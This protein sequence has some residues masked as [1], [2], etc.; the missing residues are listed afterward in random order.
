[1]KTRPVCAALILVS[2]LSGCARVPVNQLT[3]YQR[4]VAVTSME[5][6]A[7]ILAKAELRETKDP[8]LNH[9]KA[10]YLSGSP[11]EMGFQHGR[12][13]AA[14]VRS[15]VSHVIRRVLMV[16]EADMLDEVYDLMAFHI[17]VEE[18]EEMRGLAHGAGL[19]LRVIHWLHVIPEVSEFGGRKK[20]RK[21]RNGTSCSNVAAF[22][23]ATRDGSLLQL[24][25]LDW[26]RELGVHQ[27]PVILVHRPDTGYPSVT[28]S[29][30][31]FIGCVTGMNSRHLAL[32]EMGYGN[33]AGEET[34]EGLPFVFLFRKILREADSLDQALEIIRA[35]KGTCSY[36]YV[37]GDGAAGR[38]ALV[39]V[40][41]SRFDVV[42]P[43]GAFHDR[44][45]GSLWPG[46]ADVSYVSADQERFREL[47]R[48]R[49]GRL[50]VAGLKTIAK[51]I[52]RKSNIQNVIFRPE[53]LEAWVSHAESVRRDEAGRAANQKWFYMDYSDALAR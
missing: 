37:L 29:F 1:M 49:H 12:M 35:A 15:A 40:N 23:A 21:S 14:D 31:G 6:E 7:T 8:A 28:F 43:E 51:E 17:P 27:W 52:A 41:R 22:G 4:S 5:M 34:L 10:L 20:L 53:T 18:Q 39:T 45:S 25:V 19:P 47:I 26:K 42:Y 48:A 38:A 2:I 32:G 3:L 50:D 46:I 16:A 11:Y 36:A 13:I 9:L 30:A 33:P 44:R 24:R